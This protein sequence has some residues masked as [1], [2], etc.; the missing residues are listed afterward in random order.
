MIRAEI[1]ARPDDDN[2]KGYLADSLLLK[3]DEDALAEAESLYWE[4]VNS[5]KTILE[6][7]KQ[8]AY[9]YLLFQR[10]SKGKDEEGLEIAVK[11]TAEFPNNPDFCFFYGTVLYNLGKVDDAWEQY[12]RCDDLLREGTS[13]QGRYTSQ[14]VRVF[15]NMAQTAMKR[16]DWGNVVKYATLTLRQDK[17]QPDVLTPLIVVLRTQGVSATDSEIYALLGQLYDLNNVRDKV[18]VSKC[19]LAAKDGALLKI[20]YESITPEEREWI[21]ADSEVT[22]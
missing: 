1:L 8:S 9:T 20:V 12:V 10:V 21:S 13:M 4:V 11:A 18:F 15:C 16:Q 14:A 6:L 5:K 2:L 22:V 7:I 3:D 19:A 17:Y